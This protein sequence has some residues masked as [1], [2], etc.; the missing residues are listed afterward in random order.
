MKFW[1]RQTCQVGGPWSGAKV[2]GQGGGAK[3]GGHGLGPRW[4]A[5]GARGGV[6][7][8]GHMGDNQRVHAGRGGAGGGGGGALSKALSYSTARGPA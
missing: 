1:K 2:G 4:G 6:I 3:V 5:M 8:S 7:I